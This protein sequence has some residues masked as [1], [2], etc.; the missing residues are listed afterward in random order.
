MHS[1]FWCF[2]FCY[3]ATY[4]AMQTAASL[5]MRAIDRLTRARQKP[6]CTAANQN[7]MSHLRQLGRLSDR[8]A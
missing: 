8:H 2:R 3:L 6:T 4:K 1:E 7:A 5:C